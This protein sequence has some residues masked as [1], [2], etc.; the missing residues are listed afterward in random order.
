M[1]YQHFSIGV[2]L[3]LTKA[4]VSAAF[5]RFV[6]DRRRIDF[7]DAPYGADAD[8]VATVIT[9]EDWDTFGPRTLFECWS[10]AGLESLGTYPDLRF[11]VVLWQ[12]YGADSYCDLYPFANSQLNPRNPGHFLAYVSGKWWL[13]TADLQPGAL[14]PGGETLRLV[15]RIDVPANFSNSPDAA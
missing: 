13:A 15:R 3:P 10:Y 6:G 5:R 1:G 4:Q 7:S 11:A 8:I 14:K 12:E 9:G 2:S